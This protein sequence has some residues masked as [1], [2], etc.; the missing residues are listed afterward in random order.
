MLPN[1][2]K[3]INE[4]FI[5]IFSLAGRTTHKSW[6]EHL[7]EAGLLPLFFLASEFINLIKLEKIYE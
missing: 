1:C 2:H 6:R 4:K 5:S 7:Q 3:V